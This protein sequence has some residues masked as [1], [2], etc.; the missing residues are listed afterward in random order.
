MA[1]RAS[2]AL[3]ERDAHERAKQTLVD[4]MVHDIRSPASGIVMTTQAILRDRPALPEA[5]IARVQRIERTATDIL[6]MSQNILEISKLEAGMLVTELEEFSIEGII[7]DSIEKALPHIDAA[8]V[9]VTL[10]LPPTPLL[11]RA[12][13]SLTHRVLQNLLSNAIRHGRARQIR[14]SAV[15]RD[16]TVLVGV[17]DQGPGIPEE[18]QVLIFERFR[19]FDRGTAAHA[20]TGLGLPFCKMA[21]EQMGGTIWVDSAGRGATFYFTLP[22]GVAPSAAS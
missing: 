4:M 6:R 18:Y 13:R 15:P 14:L 7:R 5:Q 21:V 11:V 2:A 8:Q 9:T 12:D 20:D 10:D 16:D 3:T 17:T 1:E 22:N 19:H